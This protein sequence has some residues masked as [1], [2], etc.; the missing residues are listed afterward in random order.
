ICPACSR[1]SAAS[2]AFCTTCGTGL[3]KDCPN[4]HLGVPTK[5]EYCGR[6][7]HQFPIT[8]ESVRTRT[9]TGLTAAITGERRRA[10]I[11]YSIL[12]GCSGILEQV[13]PETA[14]RE[15]GQMRAAAAEVIAR[16]G[17]VVERCS[18]EE[19]VALFGVPSSYED[20][21]QRAVQAAIDLH[22]LR[23][24]LSVD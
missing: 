6:C 4:C 14:D 16:H 19:L 22:A 13:E 24:S 1:E 20:D 7:G 17:G 2:F 12:S 10:T 18:G 11:I 23:R 8:V 21:F 3:K 9:R 15:S 5:D